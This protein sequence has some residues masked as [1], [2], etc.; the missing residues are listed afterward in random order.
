[1]YKRDGMDGSLGV[2]SYTAPTML[3]MNNVTVHNDQT[4]C[5]ALELS[6]IFTRYCITSVCP[7]SLSLQ[8]FYLIRKFLA[9]LVLA[10]HVTPGRRLQAT[11]EK[12][13]QC[14]EVLNPPDGFVKAML[15]LLEDR[16]WSNSVEDLGVAVG[17]PK[18]NEE[19]F[20]KTTTDRLLRTIVEKLTQCKDF[21]VKD[22]STRYE[23][24]LETK[25]SLSGAECSHGSSSVKSERV[26]ALFVAGLQDEILTFGHFQEDLDRMMNSTNKVDCQACGQLLEKTVKC[27]SKEFCDPDFLTVAFAKPVCFKGRR[28]IIK[29]GASVYELKV[30]VHWDSGCASVSRK[31]GG[32]WHWHGVDESQAPDLE[33][34]AAQ[35]RSSAHL[36][37]VSVMMMVRRGDD[38]QQRESNVNGNSGRNINEEITLRDLNEG[39]KQSVLEEGS[40]SLDNNESEGNFA[41]INPHFP[42]CHSHQQ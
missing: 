37:N 2:V 22:M 3:I 27:K 6:Y 9:A 7:T 40:G 13:E 31:M 41:S 19:E 11:M 42:L 10:L 8:V 4:Y 20:V 38:L 17:A 1:M 24:I 30:V 12:W 29:F 36:Q 14:S 21:K 33:Y 39:Q 34:S 25:T 5:L 23:I 26:V 28:A 32:V 15:D 18:D 16:G 35:M